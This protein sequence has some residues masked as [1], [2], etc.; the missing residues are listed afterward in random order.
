MRG[1]Q[2][3]KEIQNCGSETGFVKRGH[4]FRAKKRQVTVE[5]H[6]IIVRCLAS[7]T[8]S[9]PNGQVRGVGIRVTDR[10]KRGDPFNTFSRRPDMSKQK[11]G[12][13]FQVIAVALIAG[14]VL[15]AWKGRS[16]S[17]SGV[18]AK[19]SR[20]DQ[21][22]PSSVKETEISTAPDFSL[23]GLD[24]KTVR[25]SDSDGQVRIVDFW[26]TWCPPCRKEIPHFQALH[27]KYGSRGLTVIGVALD[28]EGAD[29]VRPFVEQQG[30]TYASVIGNH[31]VAR[32]YGGIEA[33]PTT[34]VIDRH[35]RVFRKYVG[36]RDYETFEADVK[37]LLAQQ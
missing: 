20:N 18:E 5:L 3:W 36:Y 14:G 27:E 23:P 7:Y 35:G 4:C 22:K 29:V 10:V 6:G 37:A 30:M 31:D 24:G 25:L 12:Y 32:Q 26:A 19:G 28:E 8:E 2:F 11:Q 9:R 34:F 13:L 1:I 16:A 17:D 33:I 21:A 15:M